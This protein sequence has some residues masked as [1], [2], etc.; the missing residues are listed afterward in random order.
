MI[1]GNEYVLLFAD[2]P[3]P[4]PKPKPAFAVTYRIKDEEKSTRY[5]TFYIEVSLTGPCVF[6]GHDKED[7]SEILQ[8]NPCLDCSCLSFQGRRRPSAIMGIMR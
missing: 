4:K 1:R 5:T 2:P 6:C 7:H 3:L 8:T